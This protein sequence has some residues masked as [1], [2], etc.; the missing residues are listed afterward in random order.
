MAAEKK[1]TAAVPVPVKTIRGPQDLP[2][3]PHQASI[4]DKA[5]K[6]DISCVMAD[7][8]SGKST[9]VP[10]FL[11]SQGQRCIVSTPTV[12]AAA[13]LAKF[14]RQ[15]Y[16]QLR[17]GLACGGKVEYTDQD[18]LVYC[19]AGHLYRRLLS[20]ATDPRPLGF[21][22]LII[23]EAHTV[24]QD[25]EVLQALI[26]YFWSRKDFKLIISS[27]TLD[28]D[29]IRN[30]WNDLSPVAFT[31]IEV[32]MLPIQELY[33]PQD[34]LLGKEDE[35]QMRAIIQLLVKFNQTLPEGHFLV[36]L[37][38]AADIDKCYNALFDEKS[39]ENCA[40]Y[41]A[42]SSMPD[43]EIDKAIHQEQPQKGD[44]QRSIILSTDL[45]ETSLTIPGVV[46][47]VDS[48][49]QKVMQ[50]FNNGLSVKLTQQLASS[51]SVCQRRGRT[52]RTCA[53]TCY[54]MYTELTRHHLDGSY[55]SEL[56]RCP[57]FRTVVE[58]LSYGLEPEAVFPRL[59]GKVTQSIQ[60]L[61][62]NRLIDAERKLNADAD[63]I[64]HLPVSLQQGLWLKRIYDHVDNVCFRRTAVILVSILQATEGSSLFYFPRRNRGEDQD[65]YQ[66]RMMDHQDKFYSRFYGSNDLVTQAVVFVQFLLE[67]S[68]ASPP[69]GR[70]R[71]PPPPFKNRM[72]QWSMN[73]AINNKKLRSALR[74]SQRLAHTL[75]QKAVSQVDQQ[76]CNTMWDLSTKPGEQL[77]AW[78]EIAVEAMLPV[79]EQIYAVNVFVDAGQNK[80]RSA[81]S[82]L[83]YRIHRTNSCCQHTQA[84]RIL[85][86]TRVH[87][88]K[89]A[90]VMGFLCNV[91]PLP[92]IA[93]P[94]ELTTVSAMETFYSSDEHDERVDSPGFDSWD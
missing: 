26:R 60:Y 90:H 2:I 12:V 71:R 41:A 93:P 39:L 61:Q 31:S 34:F 77:K 57:M 78:L 5:M 46:L 13:N 70:G 82:N 36:F 44:F 62:A 20:R 73:N 55:P 52:G 51:F 59:L 83:F 22:F 30:Q 42:Y 11:A 64:V 4:A 28:L 45:C 53:G 48:G 19:T 14:T 91:I 67:V 3:Y 50:A 54:R 38:G 18:Q 49:R 76:F 58:V 65:A 1:Q 17:I 84:S 80:W 92:P 88:Q 40:V 43:Y 6:N 16:P 35:A 63:F 23:D 72:V 27:A 81:D 74:L 7:T 94:V 24:S 33:H 69:P 79:L 56:E 75:D 87:I 86:L 89:E 29:T 47:V 21:D 37:P 68:W 25:Y 15:H 9:L 8:G 85:A 32:P 66:E 10:T